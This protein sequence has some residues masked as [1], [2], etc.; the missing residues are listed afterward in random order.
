MFADLMQ[1][2]GL[3]ALIQLVGK[4]HPA[5]KALERFWLSRQGEKGFLQ[6]YCFFINH[7][8]LFVRVQ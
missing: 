2:G 5:G 4:L 3:T 6:I 7:F 1:L 8:Q